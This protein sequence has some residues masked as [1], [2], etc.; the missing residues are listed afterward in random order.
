MLIAL[1]SRI[2]ANYRTGP[3]NRFI[4]AEN[5]RYYRLKKVELIGGEMGLWLEL[6]LPED[7]DELKKDMSMAER[8]DREAM[9]GLT[10]D[11]KR[12]GT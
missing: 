10:R 1:E 11:K 12:E 2:D 5:L 3:F 7:V 9:I 6:Q 4:E 8:L